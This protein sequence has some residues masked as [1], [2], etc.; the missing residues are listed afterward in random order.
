MLFSSQRETIIDFTALNRP[1]HC[2]RERHEPT[3]GEGQLLG[4]ICSEGI[5][6]CG[7]CGETMCPRTRRDR[8]SPNSQTYTCTGR[9]QRLTQADTR[10]CSGALFGLG[11][12]SRPIFHTYGFGQGSKDISCRGR[13]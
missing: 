8:P 3:S 5:L 7:I 4:S 12:N 9:G 13:R 10:V 1:I 6:K 2:K 11:G